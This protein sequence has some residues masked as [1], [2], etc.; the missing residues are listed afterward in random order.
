MPLQLHS[1]NP[2]LGGALIGGL[3]LSVPV[4]QAAL[5]AYTLTELSM[6][7]AASSEAYAI[8]ASGQVVGSSVGRAD[9]SFFALP[10]P[11]LWQPGSA[12]PL[13][14]NGLSGFVSAKGINDSGQVVGDS[15]VDYY[16]G[17]TH[18][19]LWQAG[20]NTPSGL[21]TID[22]TNSYA[23]AIN[24]GGQ[25]VGSASV[26]GAYHAVWWATASEIFDLGTAGGSNSGA[27]GINDSGQVVGWSQTSDNA[28]S[29]AALW[30]IDPALWQG[31]TSAIDLGTLGGTNSYAEAINASGQVV[32][33]SG[34]YGNAG[35]H[36]A[37]WQPGSTTP[38]DLGTL[39]GD[40]GARS[41]NAGGQVVGHSITVGGE[42]H[43]VMWQAGSASPI[44]LNTLVAL[45]SGFLNNAMGINDA[46]Q[47]IANSSDGRAY[48]LTPAS[49]TSVP[50]PGAVWL[51]GS[52]LM[53]LVRRKKI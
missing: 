14:L 23:N 45:S 44:D 6:P 51:F 32:G 17:A 35:V 42:E 8:N 46:G 1:T 20:S 24:A 41:V 36:A 15:V 4:A 7:G 38:T 52:A 47:I 5:P 18:G 39:G 31:G 27:Y 3:M 50:L 37:L 29:H 2:L 22:G 26:Y 12:T 33:W 43:A 10:G 19:V 21:R 11:V 25:I 30:Q 16:S 9:G 40:S 28:A 13:T 48:L 34:I 53:G 49:V